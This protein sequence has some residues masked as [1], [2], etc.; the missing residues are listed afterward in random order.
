MT[1]SRSGANYVVCKV[2]VNLTTQAQEENRKPAQE[3]KNQKNVCLLP[4][5]KQ[6]NKQTQHFWHY[7]NINI[8]TRQ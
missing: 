2:K 3:P 8:L 1:I 4:A 5:F 7:K 6:S